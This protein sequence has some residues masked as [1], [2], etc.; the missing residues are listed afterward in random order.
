LLLKN[1]PQTFKNFNMKHLFIT[2]VFTGITYLSF[3]QSEIAA[4]PTDISPLLIGE[5]IPN[6][7]L[8]DVSG[9]RV[10]LLELATQK[11]SVIIFYRGGWCP[12]C[13]LHLAELQA[14]EPDIIKA[15]YQIIAISPDSPESMEASISKNKLN[16]LLLSDNRTEAAKGFGLA[17][18]TPVQSSEK[19][20]KASA[21]QNTNVLPV[22]AVF[23]I[24]PAGE[25][26]FEHINPDYKKRLKGSLLLAVLKELK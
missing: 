5:K 9:K 26:L 7:A 13:N 21:G 14:I 20:S 4:Q 1:K 11:P 18:Q 25:I 15:G 23:V 17:F 22:P 24:N 19:L 6:I 12:Y 10:N 3:S 2:L 16:Y 8:S